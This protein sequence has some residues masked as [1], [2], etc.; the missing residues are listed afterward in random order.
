MLPLAFALLG[1]I[2]GRLVTPPAMPLKGVTVELRDR[3]SE[4]LRAT[5]RTAADGRF[6]FE[7]LP[8]GEYRVSVNLAGYTTARRLVRLR[9][10]GQELDMREVPVQV[11]DYGLHGAP[12]APVAFPLPDQLDFVAASPAVSFPLCEVLQH[13]TWHHR[14][15]IRVRGL[16]RSDEEL[17]EL[18]A[19]GCA[20][21]AVEEIWLE[22]GLRHTGESLPAR[23]TAEATLTGRL[24]AL[25]ADAC[26]KSGFGPYGQYCARLVVFSVAGAAA[27]STR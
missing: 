7:G 11:E 15:L 8:V 24:E 12:V 21:A 17:L 19:P 26:G 6:R 25:P 5:T 20:R 13:P 1:A 4:A 2:T 16:V 22:Y 3:E 27:V 18:T 10:E 9:R 14:Q 23:G